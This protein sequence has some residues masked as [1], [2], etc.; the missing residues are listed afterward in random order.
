M[1]T[2]YEEKERAFLE[3]LKGDTGRDVRDWMAAIDAEGL[4]HR[5]DIIDWLRANGFIFSW[6]S[7]LERIHNNAGRPIYLDQ[8]PEPIEQ[9]HKP[10]AVSGEISDKDDLKLENVPE[11][12]KGKPYLRLVSSQSDPGSANK[13]GAS[14]R[15]FG[16]LRGDGDRETHQHDIDSDPSALDPIISKAKAYVPLAQ[17][18]IRFVRTELPDVRIESAHQHVVFNNPETFAVMAPNK[19]G[20]RLGLALGDR[21]FEPPFTK[22]QFP[23]P[24]NHLSRSFPHMILLVDARQVDSGLSGSLRAADRHVNGT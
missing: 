11:R 15:L 17:H 1:T 21:P 19:N 9:S 5:D 20:L 24:L 3:S 23:P 2:N 14:R 4:T 7:W 10:L 16:S 22:A 6:A 18:L 13:K 12:K 8:L